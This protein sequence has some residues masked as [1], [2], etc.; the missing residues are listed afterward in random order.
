[1]ER[2]Y[3]PSVP[4]RWSKMGAEEP[5]VEEENALTTIV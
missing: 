4:D 1:M 2:F 3:F 5:L